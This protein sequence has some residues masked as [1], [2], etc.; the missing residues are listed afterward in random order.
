MIWRPTKF[1]AILDLRDMQRLSL[2]A[3]GKVNFVDNS[4]ALAFQEVLVELPHMGTVTQW[5][6]IVKTALRETS[7]S[8]R[9]SL[10]YKVV[11]GGGVMS[12]E[13]NVQLFQKAMSLIRFAPHL[14]RLS[15]AMILS[16]RSAGGAYNGV[17]L[18]IE[19][20]FIH[21]PGLASDLLHQKH[22]STP[23]ACLDEQ[24]LAAF[25][26]SNFTTERAMYV[27]SGIFDGEP[28]VASLALERLQ[29]FAN[30][31]KFNQQMLNATTRRFLTREEVAV[32][33]LLVLLQSD[34]FVG[35]P[36]SSFSMF[37]SQYRI[38]HGLKGTGDVVYVRLPDH[39][40]DAWKFW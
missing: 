27:A 29:P 8:S 37:V 16:L 28:E 4:S 40:S 32:V 26:R 36:P 35:S 20:D 39:H 7:K 31:I 15:N 22:C 11:Y 14:R 24:Y 18:R 19:N 17:H 10:L 5:T 21:H 30:V 3:E 1:E 38:C 6:D 12:P 13:H 9:S 33:D 34:V 2:K 23:I 25:R